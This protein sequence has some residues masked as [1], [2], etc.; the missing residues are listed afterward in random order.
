M[1]KNYFILV[2][3]ILGMAFSGHSQNF[4]WI[5]QIGDKAGDV[6]PICKMLPEGQSIIAWVYNDYTKIDSLKTNSKKLTNPF[7]ISFLNKN[8]KAKWIWTPD[9]CSSSMYV[10]GISYSAS[11]AKIFVCGFFD[12]GATF[13]NIKYNGNTNGFIIRID[14]NGVFEKIY[15]L[16][17]DTGGIRFESMDITKNNEIILSV[18]YGNNPKFPKSKLSIPA[19]NFS[20]NKNGYFILKLSKD[21]IPQKVSE[22]AYGNKIGKFIINVQN[23][24]SLICSYTFTD[25][26]VLDKKIYFNGK[27]VNSTYLT[28]M[29]SNLKIRK[30]ALL[31]TNS[32]SYAYINAL[33]STK[34][35]SIVIS[36]V[37]EDSISL[38]KQRFK[39]MAV[40][41]YACF[42]SSLKLNWIK[43]PKINIGEHFGGEINDLEISGDYIFGGGFW[44]G[45]D[46][47]YDNFNL[48]DSLG[49]FWFFKTDIR[50][51]ILWMQR[52]A[53]SLKWQYLSSIS[54]NDQKEVLLI[55]Y[56]VDT[57]YLINKKYI[58]DGDPDVLLM[59]IND[60]DI[61]RGYVKSG[62]YCAGDTIKIPYTKNGNFNHGNQFIAQL[63][64][65][66]GNFEGKERELGRITS[67]TN[68]IIKG[69]LPLFDVESSP[70]YR[71]RILSTSPV[72]QS[73][74]K[75]DTLRLLIYSKD[76]A[77]AGKD[78]TIC[79]GQRV[80]LTTSGGSRW[81]WSP[82][83]LVQDSTA[84]STLAFPNK[85]TKYRI[86]ISD[87]SGCGK[88]DTAY[89]T[90]TV[91]PPL[92]IKGLPKDTAICKD[93]RPI[94]KIIPSG[95]LGTGF[96]YQWLSS[97][98]QPLGT[99]DTLS[100]K[101]STPG[102]IKAVLSD[103]CTIMNDTVVINFGFPISNFSQ[104]LKDT[105][106]CKNSEPILKLMPS[107]GLSSDYSYQWFSDFKL[108]ATT[109]TLRYK[110]SKPE[111]FKAILIHTCSGKQDTTFIKLT[112]P[113]LIAAKIEKPDC[114]DSSVA[115]KIA[116]TGGYKNSLNYVWYKDNKAI[117]IGK[118]TTL[119]SI[120]Q[121]QWIEAYATDFCKTTVKDSI[122]L[123]PNPK[124]KLLASTDSVCQ[125]QPI[126]LFNQSVHFNPIQSALNGFRWKNK[127]SSLTYTQTGQ[128]IIG[129]QITDS[130]GCKSNASV[131]LIVIEKPNAQFVIVPENPTVD[132][133]TIELTP[134]ETNYKKYNW[135][136]G[137]NLRLYH[138]SWQ[139]V[140]LPILDTATY[141]ATLLVSN[142]YGCADTVTKLIKIGVSDAFYIPNAVS[143]NEDGLNDE[144]APFGWKVQSYTMLVVARTNQVVFKGNTPWKPTY[145]DGVY[146]Y[147]IKV[148]FKDGTENT[149]KGHVHVI[150]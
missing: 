31:F 101:V 149:F 6:Y 115:L 125:F 1:L 146:S 141:Q 105:L 144:F 58:T 19:I 88:I 142:S 66:E 113:P 41:L 40:P 34:N 15:T 93:S 73:Y 148:K 150:H 59:K 76:T 77:N 48:H 68:G 122:H 140:R 21:L 135:A 38:I 82:G 107:N 17:V 116:G 8:G 62:P 81:R 79:E 143:N 109:D 120:T 35:G 131:S 90:I 138:K 30:N 130:L 44:G 60:I 9:S 10:S 91:R 89:K 16:P 2:Y 132:N 100:I 54:A 71:I 126:V 127:D 64:D 61:I 121:K 70:S 86:I 47:I 110:I 42:D 65:E 129:L 133:G 57:V 118:T 134:L 137:N 136:I 67:D 53:H 36:G 14:T 117:D 92:E 95:G 80:K 28:F 55:G 69:L 37:F 20:I 78:T 39:F 96:T 3:M 18:T 43:L 63:S 94:F 83:N 124:A 128:Q 102:S 45:G 145:E 123:F 103:G 87:S 85:T 75:Y 84:K 24:N 112:L 32:F 13:N 99:K 5:K 11:I 106:V 4:Q 72:V 98:N 29:D 111:T 108:L 147:V 33:K 119:S 27:N 25:T 26:L 50:G 74:Y 51:N 97:F 22:P 114:F 7:I 139:S 46:A 104:L 12:K 56:I 49:I 52:I 23:Q